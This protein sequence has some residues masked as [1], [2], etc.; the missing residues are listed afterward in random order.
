LPDDVG[1]AHRARIDRDLLC[2]REQHGTHVIERAQAAADAEWDEDVLCD[3]AHHVEHDV[4]PLVRRSDVVEDDLV[5]ALLVVVARHRD[6]IADVDVGEELYTPGYFAVAH[7]EAWNDA[8]GEH[9]NFIRQKL[10]SMR[11]PA[12]PDFSRWNWVAITL[13]RA[14]AAVNG[15][16]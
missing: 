4:A 2:S 10:S 16:P 15:T 5:G 12:A 6:R 1:I 9:Q 7:V 14:I 3:R 11:R 8:L 13:S